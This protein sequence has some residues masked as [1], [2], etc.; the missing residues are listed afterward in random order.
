MINRNRNHKL[1]KIVFLALYDD[2]TLV[3]QDHLAA[4]VQPDAGCLGSGLGGEERFEYLGFYAVLD[5]D[6]VVAD[7]EENRS[8]Q[9]L[10]HVDVDDRCEV[11]FL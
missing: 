1:G 2:G 11:L 9:P 6:A 10:F 3:V 5:A 4:E 7:A 8:V